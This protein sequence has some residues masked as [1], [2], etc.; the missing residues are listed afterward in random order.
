LALIGSFSWQFTADVEMNE[1]LTALIEPPDNG[2]KH[3]MSAMIQFSGNAN[4]IED[5][6]LAGLSLV[7]FSVLDNRNGD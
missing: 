1:S 3:T 5:G 4:D 7:W 2:S 6:A